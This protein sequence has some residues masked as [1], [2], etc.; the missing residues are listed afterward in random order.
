MN[1]QNILKSIEEASNFWED[2]AIVLLCD[3]ESTFGV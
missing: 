3:L 1:H 2:L